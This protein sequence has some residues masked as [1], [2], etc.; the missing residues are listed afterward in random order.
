MDNNRQDGL[1]QN[2]S[3]DPQEEQRQPPHQ[4]PEIPKPNMP[5]S[6][7]PDYGDKPGQTPIIKAGKKNMKNQPE[8][9]KKS[10]CC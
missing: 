10:N 7:V 5:K 4:Q 2:P 1:E 9:E 3:P 6:N 8:T